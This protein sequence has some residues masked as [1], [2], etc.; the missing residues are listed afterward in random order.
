MPSHYKLEKR[1]VCFPFIRSWHAP[2]QGETRMSKVCPVVHFEMPYDDHKRMAR[3]YSAA[4]GWQT[5]MA[6]RGDGQLCPCHNG[7]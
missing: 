3:F 4:F 6:G 1:M 2:T 7:G 5:R